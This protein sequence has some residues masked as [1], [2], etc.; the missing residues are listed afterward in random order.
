MDLAGKFDDGAVSLAGIEAGV[1]SDAG[2]G[3][4]VFADAFAGGLDG[5]V[6]GSGFE[7]ENC[8]RIAGERFS[9]FARGIAADFLVGNDENGD[10]ARQGSMPGLQRFNGVEH[11]GEAGLHIEDAGAVQ[12]AVSN[13]AGHGCERA[14]RI[15]GIEVT[16]KK[17][18]L[19]RVAAGKIDLHAI[20]EIG[21]AMDARFSAER[22][23]VAGEHG[24]HAVA[25]ELV[26]AGGF[27]FDEF[28]NGFDEGILARFEV[29]QVFRP[30]GVAGCFLWHM[31]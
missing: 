2:D 24:A 4:F 27:D 9:N 26:V 22:F 10:R 14:H 5:A 13:V 3:E 23:E 15:D 28:A 19:E 30:E 8:G 1:R 16:E 17:Y 29:M 18:R 20:G 6:S 7:N 25:G 31:A 11:E 21:G 12:T